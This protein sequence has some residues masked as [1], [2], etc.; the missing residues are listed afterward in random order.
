MNTFKAHL[1]S[2]RLINSYI[3]APA[4]YSFSPEHT[5]S[6]AFVLLLTPWLTQR[7]EQPQA[8]ATD[9]MN[10][11]TDAQA[12]VLEPEALV[13]VLQHVPVK[14]RLDACAR[15]CSAWC[16]AASVAT[17]KIELLGCTQRKCSMLQPWLSS[18]ADAVDSITIS[19][20]FDSRILAADAWV[21][22]PDSTWRMPEL[23]LPYKQ[24]GNSLTKLS[25]KLIK[26]PLAAAAASGVN[27]PAGVNCSSK[28]GAGGPFSSASLADLTALRE[29]SVTDC[30]IQLHG[31]PA[32]TALERLELSQG[33]GA[34]QGGISRG[35]A[36]AGACGPM[37][38]A[39]SA[40]TAAAG[41][42][43]VP[44]AFSSISGDIA[45]VAL[46]NLTRLTHLSLSGSCCCAEAFG[47][48]QH[49]EHLQELV[50]GWGEQPQP[51]VAGS[52]AWSLSIT[53]DDSTMPG[54]SKLTR[55]QKLVVAGA[56]EAV[57][58]AL[59]QGLPATLQHLQL[60]DCR[61]VMTLGQ[62][63]LAILAAF[64]QLR[65]LSI[66]NKR[67]P[68]SFLSAEDCMALTASSKLTYLGLTGCQMPADGC[69]KMFGAEGQLPF[70]QKLE[71]APSI[72]SD[73]AAVALLSICCP[74]LESLIIQLP[75]ATTQKPV[76]PIN[77][78]GLQQ[79][80]GLKTLVLTGVT[81]SGSS[82]FRAL[83]E[84]TELEELVISAIRGFRLADV[85][86]LTSCKQLRYLK[87]MHM[88]LTDVLAASLCLTHQVRGCCGEVIVCWGRCLELVLNG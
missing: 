17:K 48:V 80:S 76:G 43:S 51:V 50:L 30:V 38:P 27:N 13:R 52:E 54:L 49:L 53:L 11:E 23:Q 9:G 33:W 59:L 34:P 62:P 4:S 57:D 7:V 22:T 6:T 67:G 69:S 56:V 25:L 24:L 37:S 32:L 20:R 73:P 75:T 68:L 47:H 88:Q 39:M 60:D 18:C 44:A 40:M 72:L 29:L 81:V 5:C 42:G 8:Q 3:R 70:L 35:T 84:L 15:V 65:H 83:G 78:S 26:C 31:L 2:G 16:A 45:G 63:R 36:G 82:G 61:L 1:V 21:N 12:K 14:E 87:L 79:V 46:P 19:A 66:N 64:K 77:L 55:L 71:A 28:A 85:M 41:S 86:L 58:P 74:K 10:T